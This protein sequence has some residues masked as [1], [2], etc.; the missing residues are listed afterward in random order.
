[1]GGPF[2]VRMWLSWHF[3][4]LL[5]VNFWVMLKHNSLL[6]MWPGNYVVILS[7]GLLYVRFIVGGDKVPWNSSRIPKPAVFL[8][9]ELIWYF[10]SWFN[11][12]WAVWNSGWNI[13]FI[14]HLKVV[15][16]LEFMLIL[17]Q[18]REPSVRF[19]VA[20]PNDWL[21][22]GSFVIILI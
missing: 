16:I 19:W 20:D 11:I 5:A 10:I 6:F 7:G 1:M 14:S 4:S 15:L 8:E 9:Q 12:W 17:L 13:T 22:V 3:D 18:C 2:L 21:F